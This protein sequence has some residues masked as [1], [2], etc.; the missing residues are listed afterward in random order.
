MLSDACIHV[1]DWAGNKYTRQTLTKCARLPH[2]AGQAASAVGQGGSEANLSRARAQQSLG[3]EQAFRPSLCRPDPLL[4][5]PSSGVLAPL[6]GFGSRCWD[7]LRAPRNRVVPS[8][9]QHRC[10]HLRATAKH[11]RVRSKTKC[12][13]A[14]CA[15]ITSKNAQEEFDIIKSRSKNI[16][17]T[18]PMPRQNPGTWLG[19]ATRPH[20]LC[21][22]LPMR[23]LPLL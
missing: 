16:L 19:F 5:S 4:R 17:R 3:N 2:K 20:L 13:G 8:A 10:L 14:R 9:A 6:N 7:P 11:L 23:L 12:T 1:D 22:G 15:A 18:M 21:I